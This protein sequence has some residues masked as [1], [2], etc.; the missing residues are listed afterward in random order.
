[1]TPLQSAHERI[2]RSH[3]NNCEGL[4]LTHEEMDALGKLAVEE[5]RNFEATGSILPS[6]ERSVPASTDSSVLQSFDITNY[7][8]YRCAGANT[9]VHVYEM[10]NTYG[11]CMLNH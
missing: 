11:D 2:S 10:Y 4:V 5:Y 3:R 1:M 6:T 9:C 7:T 8:C